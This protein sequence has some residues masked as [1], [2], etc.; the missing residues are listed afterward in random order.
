MGCLLSCFGSK[1]DEYSLIYSPVTLYEVIECE[2]GMKFS[3]HRST[4][5]CIVCECRLQESF[6]RPEDVKTTYK[7]PKCI[8]CD[9]SFGIGKKGYCRG[10]CDK[11]VCPKCNDKYSLTNKRVNVIG[12]NYANEYGECC[13][14]C[15]N[16]I[17]NQHR[18]VT[19]PYL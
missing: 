11:F 14:R 18:T 4:P 5:R 19:A 8:N 9:K 6:G 1:N 3:G 2:C 17:S 10:C 16:R 12:F 7:S 15:S 13:E